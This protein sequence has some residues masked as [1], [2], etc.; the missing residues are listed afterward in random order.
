LQP[1][2]DPVLLREVVSPGTLTVARIE[3]IARAREPAIILDLHFASGERHATVP[4]VLVDVA[5]LLVREADPL[6]FPHAVAVALGDEVCAG[7][8]EALVGE[9]EARA[10]RNDRWREE[11]V[12]RRADPLFARAR[13]RGWYAAAPLA[14]AIPRIAPAVYARRLAA[15]HNIVAFGE[16][17]FENAAFVRDVARRWQALGTDADAAAYF[18]ITSGADDVF[19]V[20]I[21]AGEP[22]AAA[23]GATIVHTGGGGDVIVPVV[24]PLPANVLVSFDSGEGPVA[25]TFGVSARREP[26]QRAAP[27]PAVAP[28]I[29]GSGGRVALVLRPDAASVPDADLD[30]ARALA[31]GLAAEGFTVTLA[32]R[33]ADV[34]AFAPDLVHLLGVRDG[35]HAAAVARWAAQAG[36]PL[37]VHAYHEDPAAGGYWG[38]MVTRY[39]FAYSADDRNV[40]DYLALLAKRLVEVDGV[41]ARQRYA[42]PAAALGEAETVLREAAVVFVQSERERQI[43]ATIRPAGETLVVPAVPAGYPDPE[44]VGALVGSDPFVLV[45]APLESAGNQLL[46][47]RAATQVGVPI[48][49]AGPVAD[50]AYAELVREFAADDVRLVGEPTLGQAAALYRGAAI[51]ADV[52]WMGRGHAR[53]I[54]AGRCGGAIVL[55]ESRWAELPVPDR[56]RVDPADVESVA[57]GIGEA[58][59][60]VGRRDPVLGEVAEAA[61]ASV[62][63]AVRSIVAG[64]AKI[65]VDS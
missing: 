23:A 41:G 37:A 7:L 15:G 55:A 39:C 34:E 47:A 52:G 61:A 8:I 40:T 3:P 5:M 58:W 32:T 59:D 22:P 45:H 54:E 20:A 6:V 16:D 27:P 46:V 43:L 14:T 25:R 49:L 50:P 60:A 24:A 44:P 21:G 51:V 9:L 13:S 53:I 36:V 17:A 28:P 4:F 10:F 48:V 62:L 31:G 30:E 12:E 57:R 42:P 63:R 65:A 38:A 1:W 11:V 2:R 18:G 56:W 35:T 33:L 29:G 26:A 64:Y 19:D